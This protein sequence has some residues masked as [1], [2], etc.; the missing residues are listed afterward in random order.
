[1]VLKNLNYPLNFLFKISTLS[2]D[3]T[4][5]DT[6]GNFVGYVRQK[7][8]KI[9][10]EVK[11]FSDE[12]RTQELFNINATKWLDFNS[13]YNV[14]DVNGVYFGSVKRHGMRSLWRATYSIMDENEQVIF[15]VSEK[16]P[17]VTFFDNA[18]GEIP[19]INFFTGYFLN[20]SYL[21]KDNNGQIF[22]ELK[23]VRS[24]LCRRFSLHKQ[25]D[26]PDDKESLVILSLFMILLL[27]R[28]NG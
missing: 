21:V 18:I 11:V 9:K 20:P 19:V 6:E 4:I 22:F 3:F 5:T 27:E 10:E 17:W 26:I 1:M 2:S 16:N 12:S 14:T 15:T 25:Q 13:T 24:L 8:L 28:D 7:L 23:K